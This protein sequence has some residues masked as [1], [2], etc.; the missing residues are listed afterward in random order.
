MSKWLI[1][2]SLLL[3]GVAAAATVWMWVDENG[4]R[5]YSDRPVEG[6]QRIELAE[7][8]GFSAPPAPETRASGASAAE[9]EQPGQ[10]YTRLEVTQPESEQT[11]WNIEGTLEVSVA[12]EPPLREGHEVDLYFDGERQYSDSRQLTFTLD[13]VWRGVHTLEAVVLDASGQEVQ[14][15]PGRSFVVQQTSLLNPNNPNTSPPGVN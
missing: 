9:P 14:R 3:P 7:V 8:Q 2:L 12:V 11:L 6:A 4:Q 10:P 15:S 13:E 5:H 1:V